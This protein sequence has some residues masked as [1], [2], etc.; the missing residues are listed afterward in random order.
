MKYMYKHWLICPATQLS[1][2]SRSEIESFE[3]KMCVQ[4][5][6]FY[7]AIIMGSSAYIVREKLLV[8]TWSLAARIAPGGIIARIVS[9]PGLAAVL[10][11][12]I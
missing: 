6:H 11:E 8:W 10:L 2:S 5:Y 4:G 3:K 7:K 9:L 12:L 1:Y